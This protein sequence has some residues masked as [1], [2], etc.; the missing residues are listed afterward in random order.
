MT[1][2]SPVQATGRVSGQPVMRVTA[3]CGHIEIQQGLLVTENRRLQRNL[4]FPTITGKKRAALVNRFSDDSRI[5]GYRESSV[6]EKSAVPTNTGK[7]AAANPVLTAGSS[8]T[9]V[10]QLQRIADDKLGGLEGFYRKLLQPT[11]YR[12][13]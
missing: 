12:A 9:E 1:G 2:T 4:L 6:T 11:G 10:S 3:V 13:Y 7:K 5:T 8:V